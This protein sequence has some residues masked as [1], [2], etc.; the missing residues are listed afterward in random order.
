MNQQP[1]LGRSTDKDGGLLKRSLTSL[2]SL[3]G[4]QLGSRL[5]TF[6]LNQALFRLASP[7]AYGTAAIQFELILSTILFLSR[8]GIRNALLRAW[9]RNT[10]IHT[11]GSTSNDNH[12]PALTNLSALPIILGLPVS[13]ATAVSYSTLASNDV[14]RQPHFH[15]AL[16]IYVF[17]ALSELFSEP[18]HNRAM[19]EVRTGVRVRAEGLGITCKTL[20]TYLILLYDS[21]RPESGEFALL[22]FALGQLAYSSVVF[23]SYVYQMGCPT[24]LPTRLATRQSSEA[25]AFRSTF[26]RIASQYFDISSLHLSLTMTGQSIVKH[27]LTEGDKIILSWWSP[28]EDQ[29][30]YAIA[31]NYGSLVARIVFQPLEEICRVY[32]SRILCPPAEAKSTSIGAQFDRHSL[33][34]AS[35]ILLSLVSI[36][37]ACSVLVIVFATAY[38]PIFLHLLL[39]SQYLPT[40]AP[41][42][43]AAWIWYIPALAIN[44]VLEAFFSS[45]ATSQDLRRQSRWL[46][47]FS[48]VFIGS[49]IGFYASGF[50]DVSLVYANIINLAAR[51]IYAAQY[52]STF[53]SRNKTAHRWKAST[54]TWQFLLVATLSYLAI[55]MT[56]IHHQAVILLQTEGRGAILSAIVVS[57]LAQGAGMGLCCVVTWWLTSG[58]YLVRRAPV[59]T[60]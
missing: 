11:Q 26:Y 24:F 30:G 22:A 28:L 50:G 3:M 39:P 7:Q 43:L 5:L 59:R 14:R 35:E 20:V 16:T 6:I 9:P 29:G 23:F 49:A 12:V 45:I 17:A 48:V 13:L 10:T 25:A 19:G 36:Q 57:H 56:K 40:S 51:I 37:L 52:A 41:K 8:E 55:S 60:D 58:R 44:G 1:S 54:P 42:V 38:L 32:F 15:V 53:F 31:V 4:L 27:I 47:G 33:G 18:M 21:T 34:Q 46:V 2:F